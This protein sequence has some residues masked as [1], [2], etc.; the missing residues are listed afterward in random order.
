M[1]HK[2][3]VTF[4]S[5]AWTWTCLESSWIARL[6]ATGRLAPRS[7]RSGARPGF[8]GFTRIRRAPGNLRTTDSSSLRTVGTVRPQPISTHAT[9]RLS[10]S[11]RA[12]SPFSHA[13]YLANCAP[14]RA[15]ENPAS[16]PN[17]CTFGRATARHLGQVGST[18]RARWVAS[19]SDRPRSRGARHTSGQQG[20][21][22]CSHLTAPCTSRTLSARIP[23]AAQWLSMLEVKEKNPSG[24]LCAN[25]R[26]AA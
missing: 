21:E 3:K 25:S 24:H 2:T 20:T 13:S 1:P 7:A 22:H 26:T 6:A 23:E 15:L 4:G 5:S 19:S 11:A 14:R 17:I 9:R 16:P 8:S 12:S 10:L 18:P